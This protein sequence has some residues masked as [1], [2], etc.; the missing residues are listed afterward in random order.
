MT[1][2]GDTVTLVAHLNDE[3]Y[4]RPA[5]VLAVLDQ[6]NNTDTSEDTPQLN[7][8][9][10]DPEDVR[11]DRHGRVPNHYDA[12]PHETAKAPHPYTPSHPNV[13]WK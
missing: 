10:V 11:V 4:E 3:P 5:L 7:L 13:F 12:V 8:L 6:D 1:N 9:T 2:I